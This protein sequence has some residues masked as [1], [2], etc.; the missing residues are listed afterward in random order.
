MDAEST[1]PCNFCGATGEVWIGEI[2]GECPKCNGTK[3]VYEST[4][5]A[6]T[7]QEAPTIR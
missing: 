1:E 4:N 2:L 3:R 6:S 7:H 5:T